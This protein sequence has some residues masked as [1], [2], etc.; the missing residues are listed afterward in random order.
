MAL[1]QAQTVAVPGQLLG[2]SSKYSAG[3]GTHMHESNL[4]SSLLGNISI[5]QP[6]KAAGPAKRMHRIAALNNTA[7]AP[8]TGAGHLPT[9]SVSPAGGSAAEEQDK[10]E[11]LP[12]VG[13]VVLCRVTRITPREATVAI[14][15]VGDAVLSAQWQGIV[16]VQDVRATEKDRVKIYESFRPG[17]IVRAQVI[18]LGDQAN[19]YLSTANNELGV[20]MATSEAGNTMFPVSWKE[21]KDPETGLSEHRKT[22]DH[23]CPSCGHSFPPSSA[24]PHTAAL[25]Q[26]QRQI[27]DLQEQVRLLNQKATAAV[28]R[29]ADY[30]D[31]LS[32]LRAA[33]MS[34][35]STATN[36]T[37]ATAA[38]TGHHGDSNNNNSSSS[39][40]D[41]T[42]RPQTPDQGQ[43]QGQGLSANTTTS[44]STASPRTSFLGASA[45]RISQLLSP[46]K[47]APPTTT[48]TPQQQQQKQR[49]GLLSLSSSPLPPLPPSSS[50]DET[51]ALQAALTHERR[52]RAE[53]EERVAATDREVEDLSAS[54]FEQANA[55]V[56]DERRARAAL[57]ERVGE[58][59]RRDEEKRA[60]VERLEGALRRIER[61]RGVLGGEGEGEEEE[62]EKDEEEEEE[63]S[64]EETEADTDM[65][66]DTDA[67]G[68]HSSEG[69]MGS[70][71]GD[72]VE[73]QN[74]TH[75]RSGETRQQQ[76]R[77]VEA[78]G[79]DTKEGG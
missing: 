40:N 70:G 66:T 79:G 7:N 10:R 15:V 30:E 43:N 59:E 72:A 51:R 22:T 71:K 21:Y 3:P 26:A 56:A 47:S 74:K 28:D 6:E 39:S 20:I 57:E 4:Y 33:S 55:M 24:D 17:D 11:V 49:G 2:P 76:D 23:I 65:D 36:T 53:A 68:E 14:L 27:E 35:S 1:A 13:D 60:R 32:R 75:R 42:T 73:K 29:W 18:S 78:A 77:H 54:L 37:T 12:E 63:G 19:Y 44:N 58:L 67:E 16:R 69:E 64:R 31:E 8:T 25:L 62:R 38:S 9:I 61:V 48:T 46:R 41:N 45:S 34:T 50:S 52:L 5:T